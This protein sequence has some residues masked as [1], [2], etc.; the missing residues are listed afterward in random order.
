MFSVTFI[1]DEYKVFQ[2]QNGYYVTHLISA[3]ERMP[4]Q[5]QIWTE[6]VDSIEGVVFLLPNIVIPISPDFF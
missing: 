6:T 1:A 4:E 5:I 2:F 3:P